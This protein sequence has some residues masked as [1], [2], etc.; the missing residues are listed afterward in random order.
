MK[1]TVFLFLFLLC[2]I[3]ISAQNTAG[4]YCPKYPESYIVSDFYRADG[5]LNL[6]DAAP[7]DPKRM[8]FTTITVADKTYAV[9]FI[10]DYS[11]TL[12]GYEGMDS[13]ESDGSSV[14]GFKLGNRNQPEYAF[15]TKGVD[16]VLRFLYVRT[17]DGI[18]FVGIPERQQKCSPQMQEEIES[19]KRR[20]MLGVP[21]GTKQ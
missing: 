19:V 7:N 6:Y 1:K 17:R 2:I 20:I 5:E 10:M 9:V 13:K 16:K 4:L 14:F 15:I 11:E 12:W 21:A 8:E 3:P 18:Q